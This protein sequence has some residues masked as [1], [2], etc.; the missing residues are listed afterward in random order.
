MLKKS[1][2]KKN[3]DSFSRCNALT[4]ANLSCQNKTSLGVFKIE[5]RGLLVVSRALTT[6]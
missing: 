4:S 5:K 6:V 2:E 1:E 3:I